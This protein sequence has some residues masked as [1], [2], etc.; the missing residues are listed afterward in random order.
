[1]GFGAYCC[2][3]QLR[4]KSG[5]RVLIEAKPSYLEYYRDARVLRIA[6]M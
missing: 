1:M 2:L 4:G 6:P 5:C 3:D